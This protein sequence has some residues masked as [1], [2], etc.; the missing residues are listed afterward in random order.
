MG[1]RGR[2]RRGQG[3]EGF[4]GARVPRR[5]H[6]LSRRDAHAHGSTSLTALSLSKGGKRDA[7][8]RPVDRLALSCRGPADAPT[9]EATSQSTI[10]TLAPSS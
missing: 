9:G 8:T 4:V 6:S 1:R 7:R 2:L 5:G 10:S 3:R